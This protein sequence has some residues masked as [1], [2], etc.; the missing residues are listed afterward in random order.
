MGGRIALSA[1]VLLVGAAGTALA[2]PP[3]PAPK[4]GGTNAGPP[5][6]WIELGRTQKW[7]A[8]SSYCWKTACVDFILP[9]MR[10]DLPS[11]SVRRGQVTTLH[12]RFLPKKVTV[13]F[14]GAT[15]AAAKTVRLAAARVTS[16]R[17]KTA[18]VAM[19]SV[20]AAAGDA[21]YVVRI[22]LR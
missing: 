8:Y 10:R 4:V 18:G 16:W 17:P 1:V 19:I 20:T 21:S 3:G 9:T 11:L 12:F 2:V 14:V 22:K 15:G 7:L 13:S 5:P 6:A